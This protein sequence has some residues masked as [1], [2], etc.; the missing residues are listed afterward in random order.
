MTDRVLSVTIALRQQVKPRLLKKRSAKTGLPPGS[1]IHIGE[2]KPLIPRIT[3]LHYNEEECRETE[4][5]DIE[6]CPALQGTPGV[7]WINVEGISQA[8]TIEKI[9]KRFNLHPLLLEDVMNSD[10]RPKIE[11]Y[12]DYLFIVLKK[13][14]LKENDITIH[15]E[16]IS[17]VLGSG[18]AITFHEREG[19][20]FDP[21][22]Q[23][24]KNDKGRIR[25]LGADYLVYSLMDV[26]VD[27]YFTVLETFGEKMENLEV[28]LVAN[29]GTNTLKTM[30]SLKGNMIYLRKIVW[31]LR[32]V[33]SSMERDRSPLIQ[34]PTHVYLRD[35]Y[36]H[37]IHIMD[38][39]ETYRDMLAAMLDIYL[40]SISNKMNEIMKVLTIIATI[41]IPLTFIVGLYGMNFEYMPEL[42]LRWGYPAVLL[43]MF[44]I[45][46]FMVLYFKRKKWF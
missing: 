16:Q 8:E 11:D 15:A 29:P 17:M 14:Y 37:S 38:T 21:V 32:E 13:I 46:V 45:C 43:L 36:D 31:P 20:V 27:N 6:Q 33:I 4:V 2:E 26:V 41:F 40:S 9:G 5:E 7:T 10:Q 25:R 22:R 12:D 39:I 1:L 3:V 35:I 34:D 44:A 18:F 19:S 28:Q 24:L 23:Q 30:Q 42:K